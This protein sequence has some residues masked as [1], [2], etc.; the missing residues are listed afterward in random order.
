LQETSTSTS[1]SRSRS[2]SQRF[3]CSPTTRFVEQRQTYSR[4]QW[5]DISTTEEELRLLLNDLQVDPSV[6]PHFNSLVAV[7]DRLSAAA[8][9]EAARQA[10][11]APSTLDALSVIV[12]MR[13]VVTHPTRPRPSTFD[14]YEWAEAGM[15]VCYWLSLALLNTVGYHGQVAAVLE[16]KPRWTGQLRPPPWAS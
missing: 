9:A 16:D 6:R 8:A 5:K 7:R 2:R 14:V 15:H 13:N 1:N 3:S 4:S 12:K 11:P 10:K